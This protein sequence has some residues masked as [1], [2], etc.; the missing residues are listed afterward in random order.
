MGLVPTPH[1]SCSAADEI[2]ARGELAQLVVAAASVGENLH[3]I[4]AHVNVRAD[5]QIERSRE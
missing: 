1:L 3:A 2:K 5:V 4:K